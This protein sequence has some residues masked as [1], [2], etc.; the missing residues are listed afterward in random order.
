MKRSEMIKILDDILS[1]YCHA[2]YGHEMKHDVDKILTEI[3]N[4]GML[5]PSNENEYG[6]Y[7][8]SCNI[9]FG[10][11]IREHCIWEDEK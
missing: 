6:I 9:S 7:G 11:L 8:D 1:K 5:P 3:E 4:I 10:D 2:E